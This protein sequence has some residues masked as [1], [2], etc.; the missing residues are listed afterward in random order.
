[1]SHLSCGDGDV[2]SRTCRKM[3]RRSAI[4]QQRQLMVLLFYCRFAN[5]RAMGEQGDVKTAFLQRMTSMA[6]AATRAAAAALK[7]HWKRHPGVLQE[8]TKVF[9]Q[10]QGFSNFQMFSQVMIQWFSTV[11]G[12]VYQLA[13]L[14]W[15]TLRWSPG[16]PG[17]EVRGST[18][19][20]LQCQWAWH[21]SKALCRAYIL[22]EGKMCTLGGCWNKINGWCQAVAHAGAWIHAQHPTACLSPCASSQCLS[23]IW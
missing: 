2:R 5:A 23:G 14:W 22:L 21:G 16:E 6:E 20:S 12:A 19:D 17:G 3:Q 13:F 10:S 7:E 1:M 8:Q 15:L 9:Q 18:T 11:E 4:R